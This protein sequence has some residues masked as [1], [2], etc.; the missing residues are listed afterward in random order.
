MADTIILYVRDFVDISQLL[1]VA[2]GLAARGL[3]FEIK[4]KY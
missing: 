4:G 3:S 2:E 1:D